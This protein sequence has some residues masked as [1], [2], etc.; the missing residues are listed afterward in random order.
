MVSAASC[1]C[2]QRSFDGGN[3]GRLAPIASFAEDLSVESQLPGRM[4]RL[5][6]LLACAAARAEVR[7]AAESSG[8][9]S[10]G[11]PRRNCLRDAPA[12]NGTDR[13]PAEHRPS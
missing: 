8:G 11:A 2:G 6:R 13:T 12:V 7:A 3:T 10:P 5:E 1:G 9:L 4:A